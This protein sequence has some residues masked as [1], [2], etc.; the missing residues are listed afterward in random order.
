MRGLIQKRMKIDPKHIKLSK[1]NDQYYMFSDLWQPFVKALQDI[2]T[3]KD[4]INGNM[5]KQMEE[6]IAIAQ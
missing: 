3:F 2:K 5:K 4:F 1:Q 6:Q